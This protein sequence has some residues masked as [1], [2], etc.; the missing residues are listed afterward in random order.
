MIE[1]NVEIGAVSLNVADLERMVDFYCRVIGLTVQEQHPGAVT[2]GKADRVLV[3][4]RHA[5]D[6]CPAGVACGLYHLALRVPSQA[7]L[8]RWFHHYAA[9]DAPHWQGA[10]DHGVSHALYLRDPEGNGIEVY[11]DRARSEWEVADDGTITMYAHVLD[12]RTLLRDGAGSSWDGID[13][14]TDM[15]HVHLK[16]AD[17]AAA[18]RFYVGVLGFQVKAE[19]PGSALFVAAG[20]YHHHLGFNTWHSRGA[21][22]A[23]ENALGLDC[24]DVRFPDESS[25]QAALLRL[26]ATGYPA[27]NSGTSAHVR[28]PFGITL[29]L[30]VAASHHPRSIEPLLP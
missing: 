4:L 15:G 28:D 8:V 20:D 2:L 18:K 25:R 14:A 5:P 19:L 21:P 26:A 23:P 7:A 1:P 17:L 13:A 16:V 22:P 11:C 12:L 3:H 9:C 24:F 29:A 30:V 10:S 27:A 6:H